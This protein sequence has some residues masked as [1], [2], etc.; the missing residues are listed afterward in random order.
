M[1]RPPAWKK[2]AAVDGG[3]TFS[4]EVEDP[5][6]TGAGSAG[7]SS[8]G[9][10]G[11]QILRQRNQFWAVPLSAIGRSYWHRRRDQND[12]SIVL[13]SHRHDGSNGSVLAVSRFIE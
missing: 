1:L 2:V 5:P 7:A 13:H 3:A 8:S 9:N 4:G 6:A 11:K 12:I 10:C